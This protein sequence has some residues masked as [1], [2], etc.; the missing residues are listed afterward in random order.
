MAVVNES[1]VGAL[2]ELARTTPGCRRAGLWEP[3][4]WGRSRY[5]AGG[6]YH[7]DR[8]SHRRLGQYPDHRPADRGYADAPAENAGPHPATFQFGKSAATASFRQRAQ[9][10]VGARCVGAGWSR[11]ASATVWAARQVEITSEL[12]AELLRANRIGSHRSDVCLGNYAAN[13]APVK[14]EAGSVE[15]GSERGR[16]GSGGAGRRCASYP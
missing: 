7:S 4:G 13:E 8:L 11:M 14:E 12:E 10:S 5:R 1:D 9:S 2:A 3:V 16:T 6:Q 15:P